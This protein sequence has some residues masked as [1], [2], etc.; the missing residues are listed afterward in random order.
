MKTAAARQMIGRA[1]NHTMLMPHSSMKNKAAKRN[2][3]A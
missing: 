3:I 1:N 2:M